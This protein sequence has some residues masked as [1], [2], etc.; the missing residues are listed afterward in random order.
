MLPVFA[1]PASAGA[2]TGGAAYPGSAPLNGGSAPNRPPGASSSHGTLTGGGTP[3]QQSEAPATPPTIVPS[4][5]ATLLPNGKAR[6]PAGAPV[7]VRRAIRAGNRL[8]NKAYRF[9]G[10]HGQWEDTAYDCSGATS[11]AL[12]GIGGLS[13]PLDSSG[14][15]RWGAAGPGAWITTYANPQ[16]VFVVIAGLRLDTGMADA[17]GPRW[18]TAPR[19]TQNFTARH[20][21]GL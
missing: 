17:R 4:A 2:G 18:R 5:T 9:G 14:F 8:Q 7:A 12:R 6:P 19:P 13:A 15:M 16:H 21:A 3:G 1:L 10:G 11:Y 20:P